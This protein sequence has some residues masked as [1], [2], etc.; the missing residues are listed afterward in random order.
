MNEIQPSL[1][2][3]DPIG[4]NSEYLK[5]QLITYIGNK[6]AL[7]KFIAEA[8]DVARRELGKD[9][10]S[11]L[12]LF[13]GSGIVARM[14]KQ[15]STRIVAND[16]ELYSRIINECYLSNR[17]TA[18]K[19]RLEQVFALL[20]ERIRSNLAPGF[21]TELYAPRDESNIMEDDRVFYTRS[22]AIYLDTACREIS[23]LPEK[24]RKYFLA[25]LLS[26]A[27]MHANTSGVFKGFYKNGDGI[28]QY[29][30]RGKNALTRILKPINLCLPAFS[31]FECDYEVHQKE[32]GDLVG[33]IEE[34]DIAYLDPPYNQH[35]YGSNYF[36]L[37]LLC[38]YDRPTQMSR[39]SGIPTGWNRSSYNQRKEALPALCD[40]VERCRAKFLIL[41][42]NSEGFIP[43]ETFVKEMKNV[44]RVRVMDTR[45]NTFR[46][47]RNLR[48]RDIHITEMLFLV[49]KR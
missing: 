15:H 25:P 12:D 16:L 37:N 44:G 34:V 10:I 18:L 49:D 9:R 3:E 19:G 32:A 39:V 27:S 17:S 23:K 22:N 13:S 48:D 2:K 4:E 46:G 41:S 29:G 6:R 24:Y 11:F 14:A 8:V 38:N 20:L 5:S 47:C 1:F 35:P 36:M 43:R 45:Y 40:I 31:N 28:G 26:Q 30:G 42:Y 33:E 7:L 21:I